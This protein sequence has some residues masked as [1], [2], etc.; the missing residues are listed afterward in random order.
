MY[1]SKT[2]AFLVSPYMYWPVLTNIRRIDIQIFN[3]C[4]FFISVQN[5]II[6]LKISDHFYQNARFYYNNYLLHSNLVKWLWHWMFSLF[7]DKNW[8][9]LNSQFIDCKYWIKAINILKII[10]KWFNRLILI[11]FHDFTCVISILL[12][13]ISMVLITNNWQCISTIIFVIAF[14]L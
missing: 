10:Y 14:Q 3:K 8:G 4:D 11:D 12:F 5:L 1:A 7:K 9:N 2:N 6:D 13:L